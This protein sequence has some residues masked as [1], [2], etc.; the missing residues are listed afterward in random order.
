[1]TK[2]TIEDAVNNA[3]PFRVPEATTGASDAAPP[4]A[5]SAPLAPKTLDDFWHYAPDNKFLYTG[6]NDMWSAP[7]VDQVISPWPKNDHDGKPLAPSKWLARRRSVDQLT[8]APGRP[9]VED[10]VSVRDGGYM[11][12]GKTRVFNLYRP[13]NPPAGD[14]AKAD[15]WLDHLFFLYP[16]TGEHILAWL[17]HRA[18]RPGEKINHALVLGGD[19]G[20][21]KDSL[22]EPLKAAVGPWNMTE[23]SPSQMLG[24]FNG[25]AKAVVVRVSEARDL[26]DADRFAFYDHSKTF[27]AAPPD[28]LRIDEK[29]IREHQVANVCGVIFTTN[30]KSDGIFLPADDRRHHVSWSAVSREIIPDGYFV[31]FYDWLANGGTGHVAAYLKQYDLSKFNPKAPP[32]RTP[33]FYAIVQAS[34]SPDDA[35]LTDL[36]DT[37]GSP[38]TVTIEQLVD[39]ARAAGE[40]ELAD[41][42]GNRK[43]RRA[44]PHKMERAGFEPVRNPD[45]ADGLFKIDGRR[46]VVYAHKSLPPDQRVAAARRMTGHTGAFS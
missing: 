5:S 35:E 33:A 28:V 25:W 2:R 40:A 23:I 9:Q 13:P 18:Q 6:T 14:P 20:I 46:R 16:D 4:A 38:R 30:N 44:I 15:R 42:L 24:R 7:S 8:W 31:E 37:M 11:A 22:L 34:Q 32:A 26:G 17:A 1:M 41:L 3:R 21:G 27:I 43:S 12:D 39:A 45:A 29:N 36:L 19:Q 10:G